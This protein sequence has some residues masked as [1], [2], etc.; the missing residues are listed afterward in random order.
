[1]EILI[2]AISFSFYV[3]KTAYDSGGS[4]KESNAFKIEIS[5][6]IELLTL[7]INDRT[8]DFRRFTLVI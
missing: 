3:N 4:I 7:Q 5:M 8:Q 1:M 2:F 6:P